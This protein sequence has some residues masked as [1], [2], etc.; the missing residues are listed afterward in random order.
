MT[1]FNDVLIAEQEAEQSINAAKEEAVAAV[2]DAQVNHK[3][4]LETE[5]LK[6]EE[7]EKVSLVSQQEQITNLIADIQSDVRVKIVALEDRFVTH[8]ADLQ[9]IIVKSF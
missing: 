8:K 5:V 3:L 7:V 2:A 9:S 4:R 1:V 6:S